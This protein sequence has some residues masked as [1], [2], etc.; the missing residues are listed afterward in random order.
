MT[1]KRVIILISV[2]LLVIIAVVAGFVGYLQLSLF[3]VEPISKNAMTTYINEQGIDGLER[4]QDNLYE[5]FLPIEKLDDELTYKFIQ[6]EKEAGRDITS[7][8]IRIYHGFA[9]VNYLLGSF[10]V[11][12]NYDV[13]SELKDNELVTVLTAVSY[14]NKHLK[15]PAFFNELVFESIFKQ[16][17]QLQLDLTTYN[18]S[19]LFTLDGSTIE[20]EGIEAVFAL[21]L[22]ELDELVKYIDADL[23]EDYIKIYE[24]GSEEQ[25]EAL[26]WIVDYDVFKEEITS[27]IFED[28]L[29]DGLVI[30]EVLALSKPATLLKIYDKYEEL[31]LVVN[32]DKVL[33]S[34]GKLIGDAVV[35]YGQ[36]ILEAL[37]DYSEGGTLV[38]SKG[39][40]FD[41]EIM[42][43]IT[44]DTL[45]EDYKLEIDD[46]ILSRMSLAYV[47]DVVYV[48]YV[49][50]EGTTV[51]IT[52]GG[53][54]TISQDDYENLY[55]IEIP[56]EGTLTD[57]EV[58]YEELYYALFKHYGEDVFI[59]YL[60]DDGYEAYAI[61]SLES[62]YQN[63]GIVLLRRLGDVFE[64]LGDGYATAID[65]N[66]AYPDFNMNLATR[67]NEG[68]KVLT[69]NSR[70]KNNLISGLQDQG[71]M[72]EDEELI[73]CS[74]DG[75]R[76]I[77]IALNSG[78]EY[79][80][81]IYRGAFLEDIY[82]VEEALS[83]FSDIDPLVI[84]HPNP[85]NEVIN[86]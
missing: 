79:I 15:L 82:T 5:G 43:T 42:K 54:K 61:V 65:V 77:S 19:E 40:P 83:K 27:K 16:P 2:I 31:D 3:E 55:S 6:Q 22:P 25:V 60:K 85:S 84:L 18:N 33:E 59:R 12:V 1:K 64:V 11:P 71:Y 80:Y 13:S 51:G 48:V 63:F 23:N 58:I 44:I 36:I 72:E 32:K 50:E 37:K 17:K 73:Y 52:L 75:V 39:Y 7:G 35:G 76:Y 38:V 4:K 30:H 41:L 9:R 29:A 20:P 62:D 46:T 66:K 24:N 69:L 49:S 68:N 10:Y 67:M 28:Y 45:M 56:A 14:G 21:E 57:D 70:T 86:E 78:E 26:R 53:Y 74:Y 47:R 81:T 8:N 34:R